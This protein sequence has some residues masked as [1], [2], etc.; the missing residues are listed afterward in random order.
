MS[1][2]PSHD[3]AGSSSGQQQRNRDRKKAPPFFRNYNHQDPNF[4]VFEWPF[5]TSHDD[6]TS[7]SFG[8]WPRQSGVQT[9]PTADTSLTFP[10]QDRSG[11]VVSGTGIGSLID[12]TTPSN[13]IWPTSSVSQ[14]AHHVQS[15]AQSYVK[16]GDIHP[17]G[18]G[19]GMRTGQIAGDGQN[20]HFHHEQVSPETFVPQ[21]QSLDSSPFLFPAMSEAQQQHGDIGQNPSLGYQQPRT[22]TAEGKGPFYSNQ[23]YDASYGN[24]RGHDLEPKHNN[25]QE[26]HVAGNNVNGQVQNTVA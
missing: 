4:L 26:R 2:H 14:A 9:Q 5:T 12:G 20:P 18:A 15:P 21:S 8:G 19:A 10:T 3:P 17:S 23:E 22:P 6:P 25:S 16:F 24:E 1:Q 13:S 7:S 11:M